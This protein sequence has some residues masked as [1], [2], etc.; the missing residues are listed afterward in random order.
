MK[1]TITFYQQLPTGRTSSL[2]SAHGS[3]ITKRK[4]LRSFEAFGKDRVDALKEVSRVIADVVKGSPAEK[5]D[6]VD[7]VQVKCTED[8]G[9][10]L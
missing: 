7:V 6:V 2:P 9:R 1:Y 5:L 10:G 8:E 4:K 3:P